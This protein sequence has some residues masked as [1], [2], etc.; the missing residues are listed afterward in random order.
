M[1]EI[2]WLKKLQGKGY[3]EEVLELG[4]TKDLVMT[5]M[6]AGILDLRMLADV[7]DPTVLMDREVIMTAMREDGLDLQRVQS[8]LRHDREVTLS[9]VRQNGLALSYAAMKHR[10][11]RSVV[12][13]AVRQNRKA[14]EYASS[15]L[16]GD[17]ELRYCT[18]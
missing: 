10:C 8:D 9:A 17:T 13:V 14:I 16:K 2:E 6:R 5:A 12:E 1:G 3:V 18:Y 7:A 15:G 11:D 4:L